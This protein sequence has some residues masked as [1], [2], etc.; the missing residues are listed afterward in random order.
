MF[1]Q[2]LLPRFLRA[3]DCGDHQRGQTSRAVRPAA[4]CQTDGI[5]ELH[6]I[7]GHRLRVKI[8]PW[9]SSGVFV[10]LNGNLARALLLRNHG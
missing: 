2:Q 8:E 4:D 1:G 9:R 3:S 7:R 6:T 10:L 5:H